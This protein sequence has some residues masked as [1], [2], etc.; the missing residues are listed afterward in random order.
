MKRKLISVGIIAVSLLCS[1]ERNGSPDIPDNPSNT[2]NIEY[3]QTNEMD[4]PFVENNYSVDY[5]V[6]CVPSEIDIPGDCTWLKA[7]NMGE[8]MRFSV[9]ENDG[10][11]RSAE[12]KIRFYM[13][14][15]DTLIVRQAAMPSV[16]IE[17]DFELLDYYGI[18]FRCSITSIRLGED[19][20][21]IRLFAL[22]AD[23]GDKWGDGAEVPVAIFS[24]SNLMVDYL[25]DC[26][27]G[28]YTYENI[29]EIIQETGSFNIDKYVECAF[30]YIVL[31][32]N[33]NHTKLKIVS[34]P[35]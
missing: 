31:D 6:K 16:E 7:E 27:V 30:Y 14:G 19:T 22:N 15:T 25:L 18:S 35:V 29:V 24:D 12:V 13:G 3:L 5:L 28:V 4:V 23:G 21:D 33:G 11:E 10:K 26:G 34:W 8:S 9:M 32:G 1:C 2:D 20:D 17:Y